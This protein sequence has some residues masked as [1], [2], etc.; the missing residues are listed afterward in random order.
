[1]FRNE[2]GEMESMLMRV[3]RQIHQVM[4]QATVTIAT[5]RKQV[6]Q[7]TAAGL[8]LLLRVC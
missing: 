1:M 8:L 6:S 4:P 2:D 5:S 3:Y 7:G